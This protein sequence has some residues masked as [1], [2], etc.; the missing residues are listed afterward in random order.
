MGEGGIKTPRG[1]GGGGG[2]EG[3]RGRKHARK[4]E[5]E[6]G[7]AVAVRHC[8]R[9]AK[10]KGS[11]GF[12]R[13]IPRPDLGV[14]RFYRAPAEPGRGVSAQHATPPTPAPRSTRPRRGG[15][16]D[17]DRRGPRGR[18]DLATVSAVSVL[19]RCR[20]VASAA[21]SAA[22]LGPAGAAYRDYRAGARLV[23][24]AHVS[25]SSASDVAGSTPSGQLLTLAELHRPEASAFF[26]RGKKLLLF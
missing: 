9:G 12:G 14:L 5:H 19:F 2:G 6:S 8:A 18:G 7:M 13:F 17:C 11:A 26:F 25:S 23:T 1:A 16:S 22:S 15:P 4:E 21:R 10:R 3:G 20:G 24:S